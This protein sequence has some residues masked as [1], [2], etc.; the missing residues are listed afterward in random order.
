MTTHASQRLLYIDVLKII[1]TFLIV[2][3]HVS[4]L[5]VR[6]D[7]VLSQT[8]DT[9]DYI[10]NSV[11]RTA[12]ALF[13]MISGALLLRDGYRFN[14]KRRFTFI[15]KNYAFWSAVFVAAEQAMRW[16]TGNDLLPFLTMITYWIRGPYHF[17]YLQMLLGF[18]LL[19][20]VLEK[21]KGLQ[22]LSYATFLL[23]VLCYIYSPLS[24]YLP[25]C[26]QTFLAQVVII[27]AGYT[28]FFFLFGASIHRMPKVRKLAIASV[29]AIFAGLGLRLYQLFWGSAYY[30]EVITQPLFNYAELLMASGTFYLVFYLCK[31]RPVPPKVRHLSNCTLRIYIVS[32]L[33]IFA[34]E[35]LLMPAWNEL[36]PFTTLS[37]VLWS[38]IVFLCSFATAHVLAL[39]DRALA[40]RREAR[41]H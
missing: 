28:I 5:Y 27:P 30:G 16:F 6:Q 38:V 4:A 2:L 39:K 15:A 3:L 23:F 35:Y 8:A 11:T 9:L 40:A 7:A 37:V 31:G 14:L 12:L 36:V 17:W 33:F 18:Y 26:V 22:T 24:P 34:Y 13:M 21:I 1:A 41:G 10:I 25:D 29:L 32:A 19:M 20:P